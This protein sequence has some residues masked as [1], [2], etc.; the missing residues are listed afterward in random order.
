LDKK[1]VKSPWKLSKIPTKNKY[2]YIIVIPAFFERDFLPNTLKSISAQPDEYLKSILVIVVINN[3]ENANKKVVLNNFSIWKYINQMDYN[4][5]IIPVDAFSTGFELPK[6]FAGVGLARKI[7]F[8]LILPYS[9]DKSLL[10]SLDADTLISNKY[11]ITINNYKNNY[12]FDCLIPGIK[13]QKSDDNLIELGIRKYENYLYHTAKKMKNAGSPYGFITMGSAMVFTKKCYI[14]AGGIPRKKVTEDFYFLQEVV[15]TSSVKTIQ[16]K[17]VHPSPRA[18]NRVYL[19]TGFRIF[20][21]INGRDL[22]TLFYSKES[23]KILKNWIIIGKNGFTKP[24]QQILSE[25]KEV[26]I[27]LPKFLMENN[28]HKVWNGLQS[29]CKNRDRFEHQFH[30]WFDGLKTH[31]L[32]KYFSIDFPSYSQ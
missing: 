18:S 23:F 3:S 31:R 21:L 1:A 28:I 11:F 8:D 6:K 20:Q 15:K 27:Q 5:E 17:L 16:E 12:D 30:C 13:H 4:Y 19:G 24:I 14:K 32:L 2:K 26:N 9:N 25:S 10:C 29:S 7:G 22:S